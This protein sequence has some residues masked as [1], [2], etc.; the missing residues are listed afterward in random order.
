M[1]STT[2]RRQILVA[3]QEELD[4]RLRGIGDEL[5]S[6]NSR[7][8]EELAVE[9]EEDE[10]LEGMGVSGLEEM[11]AISAALERMDTGEYG[12]C[13]SCGDTIS[14]ERLDVLAYTPFCPKCAAAHAKSP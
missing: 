9:R 1:K 11:R 8:W 13:V 12:F 3:R 14:E 5:D 10:V 2:D 4:N 7:D 6:H